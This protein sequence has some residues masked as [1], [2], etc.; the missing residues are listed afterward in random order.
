MP[1][2]GMMTLTGLLLMGAGPAP[3][4][5]KADPPGAGAGG[6][7]VLGFAPLSDEESW[8]RLPVEIRTGEPLP[9]WAKVLAGP[10]PHLAAALLHLDFVHRAHSPLDPKLRAEMRWVAAHANHCAYAEAYALAD[11]RRVGLDEAA[12]ERPAAR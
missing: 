9:S 6:A 1:R 2:I 4:V 8:K 5:V 11:A 12:V 7:A 3:A 10:T